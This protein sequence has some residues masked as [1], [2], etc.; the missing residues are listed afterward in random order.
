MNRNKLY[1]S[2]RSVSDDFDAGKSDACDFAIKSVEVSNKIER[3]AFRDLILTKGLAAADKCWDKSEACLSAWVHMARVVSMGPLGENMM[4]ANWKLKERVGQLAIAD[5]ENADYNEIIGRTMLSSHVTW[6]QRFLSKV[7]GHEYPAAAN[8]EEALPYLQKAYN[9]NPTIH[10]SLYI[11]EAYRL[12][13]QGEK[14][15]EW[16]DVCKNYKYNHR[17]ILETLTHDECSAR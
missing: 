12:S 8:T 14:A 17:S 5:P 7:A 13:D 1:R 15:K 11:A 16:F 6:W 2:W 3:S 9:T 10:R 4:D